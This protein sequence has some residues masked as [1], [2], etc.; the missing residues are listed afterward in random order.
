M[1]CIVAAAAAAM[2]FAPLSALAQTTTRYVI[3]TLAGTGTAGF[4]GDGEPATTATFSNPTGIAVDSSLTVFIADQLNQCI[5]QVQAANGLISTIAGDN[6]QGLFGDGKAASAASFYDPIGVAVDANGDYYIAD[7]GNN[8]IRKV[9]AGII[10][11]FAGSGTAAGGFSGDGGAPASALLAHPIAVAVD[12]NGSVYIADYGNNRIRKVANNVITTVAGSDATALGDGGAA[13]KARLKSPKGVAVDAGGNIY[14]ADTGN[15]RVRRVDATTGIITTVAGI[16]V[17][18]FSGDGGAA[19]SA[20]L[21]YPQGVA[22]DANGD[23]FISDTSNFRIRRVS[24]GIITTISGSGRAG[25]KGDGGIATSAWLKFPA[26]IVLDGSGNIY[27]ADTQN[28]VIRKLTP[29]ADTPSIAGVIGAGAFGAFS[30]IAPGSWIEIYGSNLAGS[31]RGWTAAD[32]NGQTAPTALDGVKVSIGGQAAFI[33]YISG[34]QV[35]AQVPSNV[36]AGAQ[37][38]TVTSPTGTSQS[39][40]VTVNPTQP[41]LFAPPAFKIG[42]KQYVVAQFSDGTFVAPTGAFPG[43]TSRQA[44]PGETIVIYGVGFGTVTPGTPAGQITPGQNA[45]LAPMQVFFGNIPATLQYQG[46]APNSVGLYQFNVVVP[47]VA[48][49]DAV[50]LTFRLDGVAGTQTLYTAVKN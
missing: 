44:L 35:N 37:Q 29:M 38:I 24:K 39:Y 32:F 6:Q 27:I 9:S 30:S 19:A 47:N 42:D 20:A 48:A 11:T 25:Y 33:S 21:N 17:P 50:P 14:I 23:V 49:S 22:V 45:L 3:S 12:R 2:I 7:W 18:G 26:G 13:T 41:G 36:A 46:L 5:R 15:H 34:G 4:S 10:T 31:E 16:D 1:A 28:N 43:Y 40:P 8:S